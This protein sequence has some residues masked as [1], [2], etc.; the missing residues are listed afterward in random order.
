MSLLDKDFW[1]GYGH[2]KVNGSEKEIILNWIKEVKTV[3]YNIIDVGCGNGFFSYVLATEFPEINIIGIDSDSQYIDYAKKSFQCNNLEFINIGIQELSKHKY[4]KFD[5]VILSEVIEHLPDVNVSLKS[6]V[7]VTSKGGLV[8]VSTD[9]LYSTIANSFVNYNLLKRKVKY[10]Q[11]YNQGRV[12]DWGHHLYSFSLTTLA[13]TLKL[14]GLET[15]DYAY[16]RHQSVDSIKS[17]FKHKFEYIF[18]VFKPKI[19]LMCKNG[20]A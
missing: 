15:I 13:T 10:E 19:V 9:N 12:F 3:I 20:E 4:G 1:D 2:Y 5:C 7:D 6:I 11:W 17:F 18:P 16:S 14:V 8:I